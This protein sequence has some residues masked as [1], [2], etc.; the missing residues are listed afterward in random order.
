MSE[1]VKPSMRAETVESLHDAL[2]HRVKGT[3]LSW[4]ELAAKVEIENSTIRGWLGSKNPILPENLEKLLRRIGVDEDEVA[5]WLRRRE[6]VATEAA[7]VT[8]VGVSGGATPDS[9]HQGQFGE[10]RRVWWRWLERIVIAAAAAGAG[11]V[12]THVVEQDTSSQGAGAGTGPTPSVH[13]SVGNCGPV[14]LDL[15]SGSVLT[16][17]SHTGNLGVMLYRGPGRSF[18]REEDG[19]SEGTQV[20]VVCQ[21]LTGEMREDRRID[22]QLVRSPVWDKLDS[23][24]WI[25]HIYT[26]LPFTDGSSLVAGLDRC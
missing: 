3:G 14:Q 9:S 12:I 7:P 16:R 26:D 11:A 15:R 23:G 25:P 24:M 8:G 18:C 10:R 19:L 21:T 1:V 22:G 6:A 13:A 2:R 4:R 5:H 20:R 17:V